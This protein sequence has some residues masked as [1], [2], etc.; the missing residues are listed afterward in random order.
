MFSEK[1]E[2]KIINTKTRG[3]LPKTAF[4]AVGIG[5]II[6]GVIIGV[7]FLIK[8]TLI[9]IIVAVAGQV[10]FLVYLAIIL[11]KEY[12]LGVKN[13]KE[14]EE[15]EKTTTEIRRELEKERTKAKFHPSFQNRIQLTPK[16]V[17]FED[18]KEYI[19]MTLKQ[20]FHKEQITQA[21]LGY[22]WSQEDIEKAFSEVQQPSLINSQ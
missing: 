1:K 7:I 18:L 22:G 2:N 20:K 10:A 11:E 4:V 16:L 19:Q 5:F 15:A 3:K 14:K 9:S 21:L 6:L 8:S 12:E 17:N 13:L